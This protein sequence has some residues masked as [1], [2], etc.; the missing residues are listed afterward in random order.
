MEN[1]NKMTSKNQPDYLIP[2][3]Y[4]LNESTPTMAFE[5]DSFKIKTIKVSSFRLTFDVQGLSPLQEA[6]AAVYFNYK[7]TLVQNSIDIDKNSS[8]TFTKPQLPDSLLKNISGYVHIGNKPGIS[9]DVLLYNINYSD[10]I[11]VKNQVSSPLPGRKAMEP[12]RVD[13]ARRKPDVEPV[14]LTPDKLQEAEAIKNSPA[15]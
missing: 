15:N 1:K 7:D 10:S 13:V 4:Y 14:R 8:Y 6:K 5:I 11:A 9:S 3:F 2:P 12:A